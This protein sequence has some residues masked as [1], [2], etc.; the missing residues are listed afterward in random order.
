MPNRRLNGARNGK[1][2]E[3]SLFSACFAGVR[4]YDDHRESVLGSVGAAK[5]L[6]LLAPQFFPLWDNEIDSEYKVKK[7][8][9]APRFLARHRWAEVR[10]RVEANRRATDEQTK[11]DPAKADKRLGNLTGSSRSMDVQV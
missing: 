3:G 11:R 9:S 10:P 7:T 6:H 4:C 2:R 8:G 1:L 5:S